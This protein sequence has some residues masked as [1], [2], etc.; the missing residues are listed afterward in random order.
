MI[1]FRSFRFSS[2]SSWALL[3]AVF[4]VGCGSHP[5]A[6][7]DAIEADAQELRALSADE[8]VGTIGFGQTVGPIHYREV[9]AY[10]ALRLTAAAGD[11]ARI[12]VTSP[13]ATA[14]WVLGGDFATRAQARATGRGRALVV[15]HTFETAGTYYLAL[16]DADQE[17]T[18][19]TVS[20][21][22][23]GAAPAPTPTPPSEGGSIFDE[24]ACTGP[25]LSKAQ[26]LA[27]MAPSTTTARLGTLT[28][29]ARERLC[30]ELTGCLA[31]QPATRV[32]VSFPER[33]GPNLEYDG[34]GS[35]SLP[36]P[37]SAPVDV[38]LLVSSSQ[39]FE[40]RLSPFD[41][42]EPGASGWRF[43]LSSNQSFA[44]DRAS[45]GYAYAS[46]GV[47]PSAGVPVVGDLT[48]PQGTT[49]P[50]G[51][52][53]VLGGAI[54]EACTWAKAAGRKYGQNREYLDVEVVLSGRW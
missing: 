49:G 15:E 5:D 12:S 17:D 42:K 41:W 39:D 22:R 10:R 51:S 34:V 53:F 36:V 9:P 46:G 33:Y 8:I 45:G 40:P 38:N 50:R 23:A 30:N 20:L 27:K 24:D 52:R 29:V 14:L 31:W 35:A 47:G 1:P 4:A 18:D 13:G 32:P 2:R 54:R 6:S 37:V 25:L 7:D 43:R 19:F 3:A 21:E 26:I 11:R 48:Y 16:R 28:I 44:Y